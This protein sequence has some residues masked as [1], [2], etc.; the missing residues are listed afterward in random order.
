MKNIIF[1]SN[2]RGI[3]FSGCNLHLASV[4]KL[5]DCYFNYK[6]EQCKLHRFFDITIRKLKS[7]IKTYLNKKN[8]LFIEC[9]ISNQKKH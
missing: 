4:C 9:Q 7:V 2:K 6:S 8:N 1:L 3:L 5:N